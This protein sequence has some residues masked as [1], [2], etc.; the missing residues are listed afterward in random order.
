VIFE[1]TDRKE[2]ANQYAWAIDRLQLIE[3]NYAGLTLEQA[4]QAIGDLAKIQK[5]LLKT[6][7]EMI[8]K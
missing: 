5:G 3:D 4:K 8:V 1:N 7:R 6:L 2:L